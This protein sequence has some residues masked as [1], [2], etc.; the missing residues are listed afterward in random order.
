MHLDWEKYM[1]IQCNKVFSCQTCAFLSNKYIA[2]FFTGT[3]ALD[4][5]SQLICS[6]KCNDLNLPPIHT[7]F[8]QQNLNFKENLICQINGWIFCH[9][10]CPDV[11]LVIPGCKSDLVRNSPTWTINSHHRRVSSY[12]IECWFPRKN[13]VIWNLMLLKP[14]FIFYVFNWHEE[15]TCQQ[16]PGIE[17]E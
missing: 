12:H 4:L 10:P 11:S 7:R 9:P 17:L 1:Y 14:R 3:R 8:I 13:L 2:S 5:H 15:L 6:R 16:C